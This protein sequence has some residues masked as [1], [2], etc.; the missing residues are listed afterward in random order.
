MV[1]V[2]AFW[3][4]GILDQEISVERSCLHGLLIPSL[5][6]IFLP[7]LVLWRHWWRWKPLRCLLRISSLWLVSSGACIASNCSIH[8]GFCFWSL[9]LLTLLS[10]HISN[11]GKI[12]ALSIVETVERLTAL[13][14]ECWVPNIKLPHLLIILYHP[15]QRCK[16]PY[17]SIIT[18]CFLLLQVLFTSVAY[19]GS[20][21]CPGCMATLLQT[22]DC[23]AAAQGR[24]PESAGSNCW[25]WCNAYQAKP[26]S[27]INGSSLRLKCNARS[28]KATDHACSRDDTHIQHS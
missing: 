3:M 17:S 7:L 22:Q 12:R 9:H 6:V 26:W 24:R 8:S 14:L 19:L 23:R 16:L 13:H 4:L 18:G 5:A 15:C 10:F 2:L 27:H 21:L 11:L 20:V 28:S 1:V 25:G